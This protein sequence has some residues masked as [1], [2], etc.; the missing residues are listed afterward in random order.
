MSQAPDILAFDFDGVLCDGLIE[1][2]QTAWKVYCQLEVPQSVTPPD[3]MAVQFNRLRPIVENGWEMPLVVR[4]LVHNI[5]TDDLFSNWQAI[6]LQQLEEI[7]LSPAELGAKV[8]TTRDHWIATDLDNWLAQQFF[9]PGTI[10][11]LQHLRQAELTDANATQLFIIS[12]KDQRFIY[13]LLR[14][15]RIDFPISQI[16]G[17][18]QKQPK[19]ERLR[20]LTESFQ[21]KHHK[22]PEIWFIEDRLKTLESVKT[23]PDLQHVRLFLADWG[24]NT[25][26]DRAA[27]QADPQIDCLSL[28]AMSQ[29][30][31]YW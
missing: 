13:Q 12:T 30:F 1:Y 14:R 8:D 2:F 21:Q 26:G 16:F 15:D 6:A 29:A 22:L 4:S 23:Q 7:G 9:Y 19:A 28:Q 3:G 27:A 17:K 31:S 24:Y 25:E 11:R 10:E 20:L 5:P 18:E